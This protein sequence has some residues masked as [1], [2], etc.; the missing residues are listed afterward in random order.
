MSFSQLRFKV[1]KSFC[2]SRLDVRGQLETL[3]ALLEAIPHS[4]V[5]RIECFIPLAAI[6]GFLSLIITVVVH[7]L[8]GSKRFQLSLK[9]ENCLG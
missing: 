1:L 6:L 8:S 4:I 9:G 5:D 3:P 7:Y 2:P